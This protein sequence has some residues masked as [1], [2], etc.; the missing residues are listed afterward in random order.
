M[1]W[2][3]DCVSLLASDSKRVVLPDLVEVPVPPH[4]KTHFFPLS[5]TD[6]Y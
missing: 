4:I 2:I 3:E 5:K 1:K 6:Q